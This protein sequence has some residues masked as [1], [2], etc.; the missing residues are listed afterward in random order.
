M[1]GYGSHICPRRHCRYGQAAAKIEVS[2]VC[3]VRQTFHSGSVSHFDNGPQIAADTVISRIINKHRHRMGMLG[4]GF[5]HLLPAHS[6]GNAEPLIHVWI[7]VHRHRAAQNQ[8]VDYAFMYI[9]G[10]DD[11]ITPLACGQDHALHG[12]CRA[13]HHQKRVGC[14]KGIRRQFFCLQDDRHRVTEVIERL[15]AVYVHA[16]AL[17]SQKCGQFW[18]APAP[19]VARHVEGNNPHLPEGFQRLINGCAVLTRLIGMELRIFQFFLTP[20]F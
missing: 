3:L 4:D 11:F 9:A 12:A 18:I 19:L 15:H 1:H 2:A 20:S 7:D 10:Q 13:A 5:R 8:S 16:D 17:L 6:K 14:A